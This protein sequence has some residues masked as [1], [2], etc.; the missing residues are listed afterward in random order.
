M[1]KKKATATGRVAQIFWSNDEI[2]IGMLDDQTKF[3]GFMPQ[4]HL[5][6][7]VTLHGTWYDHPQHGEQIDVRWYTFPK[8]DECDEG[9]LAIADACKFLFKELELEKRGEKIFQVYKGMAR[10]AVTENPYLI[11]HHVSQIGFKTVDKI[12]EKLGIGPHDK[13]RVDAKID[14]IMQRATH[15][16]GHTYLSWSKVIQIASAELELDYDFVEE[17]VLRLTKDGVNVFGDTIPPRLVIEKDSGNK[18]LVYPRYLHV[19]ELKLAEHIEDLLASPP[20][21]FPNGA[22]LPEELDEITH[23]G[24]T[25]TLSDEQREAVTTALSESISIITGGPGVGKTTIVKKIV[26][27]CV[28]ANLNVDLCSFT[29]RAAR[30]LGE[31][32]GREARTIHKLLAYDPRSRKFQFNEKT[33]LSS[34]VIICDETS[35]VNM[36]IGSCLFRAIEQGSR[37]VL[38]GDVDQLPPIGPG[39]LFRDLIASKMIPTVRLNTIYRQAASSLI[40]RGSREILERQV[41]TFGNKDSDPQD[42]LYRFAYPSL[43]RGMQMVI[44]LVTEKIPSQFGI[45]PNDIQVL[46]PMY[47]GPLGI[48]KLNEELQWRLRG[49]RPENGRFIEG[50]KVIFSDKNDYDLGVMNGDLGHVVRIEEVRRKKKMA[51]EVTIEID[52]IPYT[53]DEAQQKNLFLAYVISIHK[54]QGSEYPA[55]VVLATPG[56]RPGFYNRN[57]LYTA[58]T[59]GK[60]LSIIVTPAG[61]ST[62]KVIVDTDEKKRNSR[63]IEKMSNNEWREE[64]TGPRNRDVHQETFP[65]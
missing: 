10:N 25:I 26:D 33:P 37:V 36:Y 44:D 41:P 40:I 30:R 19:A 9:Q 5:G 3:K 54:C 28:K 21:P 23:R 27:I 55:S 64:V 38:V 13:R 11:T 42:D 43:D 8:E 65:N 51:L 17:S 59:R 32:A 52:G 48:H 34:D 47:D 39:A 60:E 2:L 18:R 63:L 22:P 46:A 6:D 14:E 57:M 7:Y 53:L 1:S 20:K 49:E 12:A 29:G 62:L 16:G 24:E 35:M 56:G 61:D 4:V 50:D 31:A 15:D 58:M 45:D